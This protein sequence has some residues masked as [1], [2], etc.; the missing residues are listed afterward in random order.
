M[1]GT[2][3]ADAVKVACSAPYAEEVHWLQGKCRAGCL[4]ENQ[5]CAEFTRSYPRVSTG[6]IVIVLQGPC[7]AQHA[8]RMR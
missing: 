8:G 7:S 3:K 1:G 6:T 5:E 2:L 4:G